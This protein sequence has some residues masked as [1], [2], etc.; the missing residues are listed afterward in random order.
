MVTKYCT[1]GL[2]GFSVIQPHH[3]YLE[4]LIQLHNLPTVLLRGY[5]LMANFKLY[6]N[7]T[8]FKVQLSPD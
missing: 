2:V 8:V 6:G 7:F 3:L 4:D 5:V 1:Q